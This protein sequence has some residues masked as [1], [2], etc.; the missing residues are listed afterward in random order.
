MMGSREA[1]SGHQGPSAFLRNH[2]TDRTDKEDPLS[3]ENEA[4]E[5]LEIP[6][7]RKQRFKPSVLEVMIG[8]LILLGIMYM[9]FLVLNKETGDTRGTEARIKALEARIDQRGSAAEKGLEGL[10]ESSRQ[11]EA[12]LKSLEDHRKQ[13][14]S[15]VEDLAGKAA[16]APPKVST[17]DRKP[18]ASVPG[19]E[20]ISHKVKKGET[21]IVIA[22]KYRVSTQDIIQWNKLSQG[23]AIKPD[24][25]LIIYVKK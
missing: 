7:P 21:L 20:R 22:K 9:A 19:K 3:P 17:E 6:V 14:D 12:R 5:N 16:P 10:K 23:K 25:K 8:G 15:R 18:A 1:P 13:V 4:P 11:F 2:P 24:D